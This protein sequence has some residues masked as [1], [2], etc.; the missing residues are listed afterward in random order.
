MCLECGCGLNPLQRWPKPKRQPAAEQQISVQQSLLAANDA[1]AA[2]NRARLQQHGILTLNLMSS[3]GAGKTAL[4]EALIPLLAPLRCAV[5]VGDLQT[6]NDAQRIRTTG[7]PTLQITTGQ[8]CHL[9]ANMVAGVLDQLNLAAIDILFIENVGN[10]VCP[11]SFDLGEDKRIALLSVC[12]GD[13]KPA[14]YPTLFYK[15]DLLLIT[16]SDLLPHLP[17]FSPMRAENALRQLAN[18]APSLT[19][20]SFQSA[21]LDPLIDWLH[22]EQAKARIA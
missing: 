2:A 4:L 13:D 9:D 6:D 17:Q 14:K 11:A 10:L 19:L 21:S 20:S 18:S 5:I 15:A 7:A 1:T 22:R 12:E 16:K 8:A 3:P